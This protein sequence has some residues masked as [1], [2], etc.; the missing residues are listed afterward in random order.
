MYTQLEE[1]FG[2]GAAGLR[3]LRKFKKPT[4][5]IFYARGNSDLF[6]PFWEIVLGWSISQITSAFCGIF[7]SKLRSEA[8]NVLLKSY[9]FYF[10]NQA[11]M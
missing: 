11:S 1:D 2:L 4:I 8:F 7:T 10:S 9:N 5:A 6:T 3:N